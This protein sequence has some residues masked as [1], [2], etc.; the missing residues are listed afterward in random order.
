MQ[1]YEMMKRNKGSGKSIIAAARKLATVIWH[2][3]SGNAGFDAALML[4]RKLADKAAAMHDAAVGRETDA[5]ADTETEA[6]L[7]AVTREYV[8]R[9]DKPPALPVKKRLK[10]G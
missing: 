2:M 8:I 9:M 10:V 1:R 7:Q 5:F 3:L 4:D 6:A